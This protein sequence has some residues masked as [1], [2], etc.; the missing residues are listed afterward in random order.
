MRKRER[1]RERLVV[2]WSW[3]AKEIEERWMAY[4]SRNEDGEKVIYET[5][6]KT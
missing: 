3:R 5:N 6:C 2:G 1:E 4:K